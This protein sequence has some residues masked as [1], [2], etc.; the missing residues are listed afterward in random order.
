MVKVKICGLSRIEDALT[1]AKEGADAL[2]FVFAE[3]KRRVTPE[4]VK[5]IIDRLPPYITTVGV[6]VDENIATIREIAKYCRLDLIQLHGHESPEYCRELNLKVV[7]GFR[8]KDTESLN[9]LL[10][11]RGLVQGFLLDTYIPGVAGGTGETFDWQ[12]AIKAKEFG[13][14]ILAGGLHTENIDR[15]IADVHP[16]AVDVSS[17]VETGG[18]KDAAKIKSFIEQVRR[19]NL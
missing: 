15:A 2:G 9:E 11:Y 12:L 7:K 18:M 10:P 8:V 16:Y 17:G 5:S 3:S 14:V 19:I 6:F 13:P 1:A 4:V